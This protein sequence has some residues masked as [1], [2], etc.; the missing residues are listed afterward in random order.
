MAAPPLR[1][2]AKKRKRVLIRT[3]ARDIRPGRS[4]RGSRQGSADAHSTRLV[5]LVLRACRRDF[6]GQHSIAE[7]AKDDHDQET[8]A[9]AL[10]LKRGPE[11]APRKTQLVLTGTIH[12][13]WETNGSRVCAR[14]IQ[15]ARETIQFCTRQN[16]SPTE[17]LRL[18]GLGGPDTSLPRSSKGW[19]KCKVESEAKTAVLKS[20][21]MMRRARARS[22]QRKGPQLTDGLRHGLPVSCKSSENSEN[23]APPNADRS[24]LRERRK[25]LVAKSMLFGPNLRLRAH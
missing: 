22:Q 4:F 19:E 1:L 2:R 25:H 8:C 10:S 21:L 23:E 14:S 3:H 24:E 17:L 20:S 7:P 15:P 18:R 13:C 5:P 16:R 9:T 11:N 6:V 12:K